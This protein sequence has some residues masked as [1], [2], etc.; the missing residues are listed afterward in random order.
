MP[1]G[2][3]IRL[4]TWQHTMCSCRPSQFGFLGPCQPPCSSRHTTR[5]VPYELR[6]LPSPVRPAPSASLTPDT[7]PL[8]Y[9]EAFA[10]HNVKR[11]TVAREHHSWAAV[12]FSSPG[13]VTQVPPQKTQCSRKGSAMRRAGTGYPF[14]KNHAVNGDGSDQH[15]PYAVF[16]SYRAGYVDEEPA[17]NEYIVI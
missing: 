4:L 14:E 6:Q 5:Y 12:L 17:A 8:K 11:A 3:L 15:S 7:L 10:V 9:R 13:K 1:V 2:F 16:Q